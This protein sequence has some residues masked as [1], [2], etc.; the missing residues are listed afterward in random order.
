M[1][2]T[3][4]I[5][6]SAI[7]AEFPALAL[8]QDGRPVVF[9]DGPGG[10][11]VSR[12][13]IEAVADYYRTAN[14]N[15]G[16]AFATSERSDRIVAEARA[17]VADLYG[18]PSPAE[19]KFGYNMTT[20]T[21]HL[22]RSIAASLAPGGEIVVTQLDHE[23]NVSPWQAVARDRGLSLVTVDVHPEDCTLD[24]D[25]LERKLSPHTR[26]VA[27]GFASNAVGTINPVAEIAQRAHAVGAWL[28]VDAVHYAPHDAIDVIAVG[29]D[30]L[31]TSA[32]K[33]YGPH[34]G[35]LWARADLLAQLPRYKVRPAHDDFETGTPNME[36]IAGTGAAVG[37]LESIG[38]R[39]GDAANGDRRTA[40]LEAMRLIR[41]HELDLLG[42]LMAGLSS[43]PGVRFWGITDPARF[44]AER[45]PT[46]SITIAGVPARA[47]AT[48]LARH[49]IFA[50]DGD[51]YARAL[52]ERLGLADSGGLLRLGIVHYNIAAEI[53]RALEAIEAIAG[54]R[55]RLPD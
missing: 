53:D 20:L 16:G 21:F 35:A 28:Y 19:I 24:L 47:A 34:L 52:V 43:I 39:F 27:V 31:V 44:A 18:A 55:D 40:L 38:R 23:A 32:Y 14:A 11:Q 9:L 10:T 12:H 8:E 33:W 48:S 54:R 22:S 49:G 25:D 6:V 29:A 46:V 41:A 51:F 13:V 26:L 7:R 17:A 1:R 37:Y 4:G 42:R 30:F 3:A 50:W 2:A 36:A 45:A 5:D 15:E